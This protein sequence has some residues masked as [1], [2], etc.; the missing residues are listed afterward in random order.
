MAEGRFV[1]GC[2]L[3]GF[4][5]KNCK[6]QDPYCNR[7]KFTIPKETSNDMSHYFR[8]IKVEEIGDY[9]CQEV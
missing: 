7:G 3:V 9:L 4:E 2:P 8:S 6:G 1:M 5:C